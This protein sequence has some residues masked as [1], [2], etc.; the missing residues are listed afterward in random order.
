MLSESIKGAVNTILVDVDSPDSPFQLPLFSVDLVS[1]PLDSISIPL[2]FVSGVEQ[3]F[4]WVC[5][6]MGLL[7]FQRREIF[8]LCFAICSCANLRSAAVP[9]IAST[10]FFILINL[11]PS[12]PRLF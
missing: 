12:F 11:L 5:T 7:S 2:N 8:S 6:E 3:I 1:L 9:R 10:L 4:A